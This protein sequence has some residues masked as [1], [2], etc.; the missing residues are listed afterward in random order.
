MGSFAQR[1][2]R[3]RTRIENLM[4]RWCRLES[5]LRNFFGPPRVAC[6]KVLSKL[7]KDAL[8]AC[9]ERPRN[10]PRWI[11]W[12]FLIIQTSYC[13][14]HRRV[15]SDTAGELNLQN[16]NYNINSL[17]WKLIFCIYYFF[18]YFLYTLLLFRDLLS[19]SSNRAL[20]LE[21]TLGTSWGIVSV[22]NCRRPLI[23][24]CISFLT[25]NASSKAIFLCEKFKQF[26][27]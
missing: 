10:C 12:K 26:S 21:K 23:I 20:C 27:L 17:H 18:L 11:G 8:A 24:A 19:R 2:R 22:F 14:S 13:R 15:Y 7:Q 25:L 1:K 9:T 4:N 16:I 3:Y 6:L 5:L